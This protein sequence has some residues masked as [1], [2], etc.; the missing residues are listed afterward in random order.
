MQKNRDPY[1][2]PASELGG[3]PRASGGSLDQAMTQDMGWRVGDVM[4]EA[5]QLVS[6]FKGSYWAALLMY[7]LIAAG[8]TFVTGLFGGDSA[9]LRFVG[10]M[11]AY[12]VTLPLFAG[13]YVLAI[14]RAAGRDVSWNDILGYFDRML[15]LFLLFVAVGV[16][17]MVGFI[18]LILPGIYLMIAYLFA[19]PLMVEKNL[20]LWDAMEASR[21][22]ITRCWFRFFGLSLLI[23][24]VLIVSTIP[25][26]IGLIWS[27]PWAG[28]CFGVVYRE[29]YGVEQG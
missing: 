5:W 20:S 19:M 28:L 2:A 11:I 13:I 17:T 26:G 4:G 15:P 12:L 9:L 29:M 16:L 1:T 10:E 21:K 24:L 25:L 14:H 18:F 23:F 27:V 3:E 7:M 22:S 8:M 6:G